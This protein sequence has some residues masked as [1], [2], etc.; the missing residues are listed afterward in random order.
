MQVDAFMLAN[1]AEVRNGMAYVLGG[2]WTQ[3]WPLPDQTYPH[4]RSIGLLIAIRAGYDEIGTEHALR[5]EVRDPEG[6]ALDSRPLDG[7]L[8]IERS[9]GTKPGVSHLIQIAG[10][11]PV[12]IPA[13]GIYAVVLLIDGAE[14]HRI[15]FEALAEPPTPA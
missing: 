11:L 4:E 7:A 8:K 9:P 5:V 1:A 12:T 3:C 15:Q 10:S 6:S 13:P 14:A 2:G